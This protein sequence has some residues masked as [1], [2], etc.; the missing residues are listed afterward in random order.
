M[1]IGVNCLELNNNIG[2]L[3]Q[4]FQRLFEELLNCDQENE[5]VF[6]YK[7]DNVD[8]IE[9]VGNDRWKTN[10][11]LVANS[12]EVLS[13][14]G[15]ID[16]LFCPFNLLSPR[17]LPVA[18]V[19]Q[20]ADIQEVFYPAF[21]SP[22]VLEWRRNNYPQSTRLADAVVTLSEFSKKTIVEHHY[23]NPDKLFVS[24]LAADNFR[25]ASD[26]Q[27]LK[28]VPS[29]FLYF[30]ANYW[31]HKNHI[32]LLDALL[33]LRSEYDLII[34]AVF[35][36][37]EVEGGLPVKETVNRYGLADQIYN[38]GYVTEDQVKLLYLKAKL[39]CFPSKFEGF[40]MPVLEAMVLGCPV[41]CS[42][43]TSLPE[44]CGDAALYFDPDDP[45]DIAKVI[46]ELWQSELLRNEL[47]TKG[48]VRGKMF[49]SKMMADIHL[50]AFAYAYESY[51]KESQMMYRSVFYNRLSELESIVIQLHDIVST[52]RSSWSWRITAP[53]RWIAD[54][55]VK[56]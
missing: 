44:V 17:P 3:R 16:V 24:Y 1:K 54:R 43:T 38:L 40:G 11:R 4:Y 14:L 8:E 22:A 55:L 56:K 32:N 35:T 27:N 46:K 19:V 49:S 52:L 23:V 50:K 42:G 26:Q 31:K 36:G 39:L 53:I 28:N 30:P 12:S 20:L 18:S 48:N 10:S 5:Y 6:F 45:Y 47:I 37:H 21:F 33:I 29:E 7:P 41:A 25:S 15:D 13:K 9:L 34:P 51:G 2:G